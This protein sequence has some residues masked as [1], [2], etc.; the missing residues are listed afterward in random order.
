V[1]DVSGADS[2]GMTTPS[3]KRARLVSGSAHSGRTAS[4]SSY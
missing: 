3:D 4:G 1:T 2:S